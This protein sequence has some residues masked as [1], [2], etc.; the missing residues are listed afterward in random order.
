MSGQKFEI[1]YV[2]KILKAKVHSEGIGRKSKKVW[3][4]LTTWE[5]YE[6]ETWEPIQIFTE[7]QYAVKLFWKNAD[8]GGRNHEKISQFCLGEVIHLKT[9]SS[10]TPKRKPGPGRSSASLITGTRVFALWPETQHYY[11]AVVQRRSGAG[12][13]VDMRPCQKLRAGD[14]VILKTDSVV[15]ADFQ[16][17]GAI[18]V[19]KNV[20]YSSIM[21]SAYEIDQ[22]WDDRV[23]SHSDIVCANG[24]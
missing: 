9:P 10:K 16:D 20:D 8:C 12:G 14:T 1:F 7:P 13:Y 21:I 18:V 19:N 11:S 17:D 5:G 3:L 15:V 4:Y 22:E 6:D 24:K 23:L 2:N